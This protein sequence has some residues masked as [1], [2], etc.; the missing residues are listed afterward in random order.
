M[1]DVPVQDI[2]R[3][4]QTPGVKVTRGPGEPQHLLLLRHDVRRARFV[5]CRRQPLRQSTEVREAM[6]LAID[7]DAI[8]Q[9]VMRG[10]VAAVGRAA[11]ALRERLD[12]GDGRLRRTRRGDGAGAHGGGR[13]SRRLLRQLDCPNDR[14]INDEAI[15]QAV[16]GMLARIGITANLNAQT[17]SLHFP[18]IENWETDFYLLGWGVP[19]FDSQY[20]FDF[21]VHTREGGYGSFNGARYSNP[22]LDARSSRWRRG[23]TSRPATK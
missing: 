8:Q 21:L 20:V 2:V 4:E 3:L 9:V 5:Q 22:E 23:P 15:C 12:R 18:L 19:T 13:L 7:R 6:A 14:Y 11:A 17:R 16:V 10:G 1:Q